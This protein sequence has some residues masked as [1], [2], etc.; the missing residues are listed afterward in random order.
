LVDFDGAFY[1]A[2]LHVHRKEWSLAREAI[3]AA[4]AAMDSRFTALM[5]E[6]YKRAYPSMVTAQTLSEMEEI[7]SY[8]MLEERYAASANRHPVN[9]PDKDKARTELLSI[10]SDRLAGCRE[11]ADV[12]SS[13][14]AVRS[15]VLNPSDCVE[16]TLTQSELSRQAHRFKLAE[17]VLLEPLT[18]LGADINGSIFGFG[19][20]DSLG[21]GLV[22]SQAENL[23]INA[24][25]IDRLVNGEPRT[26]SP[27]YGTVHER[28]SKKVVQEAGGLDK[29]VCFCSR[30]G[31]ILDYGAH[32]GISPL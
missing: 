1:T 30:S 5:A 11:D 24:S 22:Q 23:E 27:K 2:V 32:N 9:R 14:L 26:F 16:C 12:Y 6:S 17:R 10:W 7:I 21:L 18:A 20:P 29:Y 4:R 13:I 3:D 31:H 28:Y 8:R 19:L 15:L 25:I